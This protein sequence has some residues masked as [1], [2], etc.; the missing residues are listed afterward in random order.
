MWECP[1]CPHLLDTASD[2]HGFPSDVA[3]GIEIV[4]DDGC[5]LAVHD[6]VIYISD[7]PSNR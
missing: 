1:Y 3:G 2:C 7:T 4:C 5:G 6:G